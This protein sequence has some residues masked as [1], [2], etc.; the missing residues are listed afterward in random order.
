MPRVIPFGVREDINH[1]PAE[2]S[3]TIVLMFFF[4]FSLGAKL[5]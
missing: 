4:F 5:R 3:G 1:H 2:F